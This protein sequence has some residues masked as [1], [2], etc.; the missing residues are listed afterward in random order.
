MKVLICSYF[1]FPKGDAGAIR[2]EKFAYMLKDLGYDVLVVGLG[3]AC[4]F[5][6]LDFNDIKYTSLRLSGSGFSTKVKSRLGFWKNL[7]MVMADYNPDI[8]IMGDM[9]PYVTV[10]LKSY[11]KKNSIKLL[12]DSVEWYSPEQF[13]FGVFSL[14]CINKNILNRYLIDKSVRVVSISSYLHNH[15]SKKGIKSV[16]IPIVLAPSDL[17]EEKNCGEVVQFMYAGQPGKKDNLHM[18][19]EAFYLLPEEFKGKFKLHIIGCTKEQIIASGIPSEHVEKLGDSL[20]IYGRVPHNKVLEIFKVIDFTLLMRSPVQRYA[21]AG[22]PTK[23]PESLSRSTPMIANLT[24]DIGLYLKDGYNALI[25]S[26]YT[27][28]SM[29]EALVRALSLSQDE[30]K[31]MRENA[32]KTASTQLQYTEFLESLKEILNY[33]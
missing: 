1:K 3:D 15:F 22:F 24:S 6:T 12:H 5:E 20:E 26:E 21:K 4:N 2:C 29:S 9:R 27:V 13:K 28:K 30:R 19:L 7:K 31:T 33:D 25:V 11:C 17:C 32:Y 16:N 14:D 8:V 10:K 23:M 18:F